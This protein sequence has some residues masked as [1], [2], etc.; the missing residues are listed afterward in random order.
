MELDDTASDLAEPV[1]FLDPDMTATVAS[2]RLA[3]GPAS[4]G[5][6]L[7]RKGTLTAI[8]TAE[9]LRDAG[10]EALGNL[11]RPVPSPPVVDATTPMWRVAEEFAVTL[12][13]SPAIIGVV[14]R[15]G[16]R[17]IGILPS[18]LVQSAA[19]DSGA[20]H[21]VDRLEGGSVDVL[22]FQCPVDHERRIITFYDRSAP[23]RCRR[24]HPME[25][26]R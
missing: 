13:Q 20:R 6:V 10:E 17:I 23:P 14:V 22:M 16:A 4:F 24:G 19:L 18:D 25:P 1:E 26:M 7:D 21:G 11:S 15:A 9:T 12:S 8:V 5:V 3:G 2:A